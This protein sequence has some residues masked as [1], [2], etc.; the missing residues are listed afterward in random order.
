MVSE[1]N[2]A[3]QYF[4]W[5]Q[6]CFCWTASIH[7]SK[8]NLTDILFYED[9]NESSSVFVWDC[10]T[11]LNESPSDKPENPVF[12]WNCCLTFDGYQKMWKRIQVIKSPFFDVALNVTS[13][14]PVHGDVTPHEFSWNE[15]WTL[16]WSELI[17]CI[18]YGES[19]AQLLERKKY[20][21]VMSQS[22]GA[23]IRTASDWFFSG[24]VLS[25]TW[26]GV[27]DWTGDIVCDQV[28]GML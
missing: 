21:K 23:R 18:A 9:L 11:V 19:I 16:R 17:F 28:Q 15:P 22:Y 7:S 24:I 20:E 5:F 27:I 4:L 1:W 25:A 13:R 14:S 12:L 3:R 10:W 2:A 8:R 6:F 26:R